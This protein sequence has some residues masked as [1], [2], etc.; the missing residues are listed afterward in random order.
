MVL[1]R[2]IE[3]KKPHRNDEDFCVVELPGLALQIFFLTEKFRRP[4]LAVFAF[5]CHPQTSGG[6]SNSDIAAPVLAPRNQAVGFFCSTKQ[7]AP[8]K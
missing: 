1:H 7:K 4:L 3:N 8:S 2:Q 6:S 5:R